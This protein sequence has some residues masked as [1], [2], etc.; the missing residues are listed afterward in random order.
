MTSCASL[1]EKSVPSA[2]ATFLISYPCSRAVW[3]TTHFHTFLVLVLLPLLIYDLLELWIAT[4]QWH[5]VVASSS[6]LKIFKK[7]KSL[8]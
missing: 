8:E 3:C 1:H 2:A 5:L 6:F 4:E 7:W